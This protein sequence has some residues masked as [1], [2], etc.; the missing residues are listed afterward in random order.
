MMMIMMIIVMMIII[1]KNNNRY[2][3]HHHHY[4]H[5]DKV[6]NVW[7]K[8]LNKNGRNKPTIQLLR[9]RWQWFIFVRS[10]RVYIT[11]MSQAMFCCH[12]AG[13][14]L[15]ILLVIH[16]EHRHIT[17]RRLMIPRICAFVSKSS[18]TI[19]VISGEHPRLGCSHFNSNNISDVEMRSSNAIDNRAV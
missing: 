19:I 18:V 2:Y 14:V 3:H 12:W 17:R 9:I 8:K 15:F 16:G 6:R 1:I 7:P 10:H 13:R 11:L 4:Y 5:H